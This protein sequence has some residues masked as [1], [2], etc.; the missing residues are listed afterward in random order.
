[1]AIMREVNL[2]GLVDVTTIAERLQ[3]NPATVSRWTSRR[4]QWFQAS[5]PKPIDAPYVHHRMWLWPEVRA[6]ARST[7]RLPREDRFDDFP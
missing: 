1:M 3:V 7:R 4:S 6:W 2:H 5:F